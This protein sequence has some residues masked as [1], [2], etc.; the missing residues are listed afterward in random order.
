VSRNSLL[1][2]LVDVEGTFLAICMLQ[3]HAHAAFV[4]LRELNPYVATCLHDSK[5]NAHITSSIPRTFAPEVHHGNAAAAGTSSFG[6]SGVNA[7]I[8]MTINCKV[9]CVNDSGKARYGHCTEMNEMQT[10]K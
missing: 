2:L 9:S 6:M 3:Q 5:C 8:L 7:H 10:V 1:I 4:N